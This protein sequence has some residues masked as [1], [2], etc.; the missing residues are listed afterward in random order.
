VYK[1]IE[2]KDR[3]EKFMS[4][5]LCQ[6][7]LAFEKEEVPV[8]AVLVVGDNIVA[9]AHN[10]VELQGD[11]TQHAEI[12]CLQQGAKAI[13]NWR[14]ANATMYSTLEPCPMCAGAM[15]HCRLSVLVWAAPD[16]RCGAHGSWINMLD[17]VHP[18]HRVQVRK[19]V[20]EKEASELMRSFFRKRRTQ[21]R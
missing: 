21:G 13:G 17:A 1:L 12:L 19:G 14:L 15:I 20:L 18:I 9:R 2:M 11:G 7:R 5:A 8:G 10:C 3:D 4:E 6:A 16:L